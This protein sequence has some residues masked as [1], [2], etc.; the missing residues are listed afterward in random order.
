MFKW[1]KKLIVD[2]T[3]LMFTR[4]CWWILPICFM[5]GFSAPSFF[6]NNYWIMLLFG[7]LSYPLALLVA[8]SELRVKNNKKFM[9]NVVEHVV[10]S[11]QKE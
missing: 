5:F 7:V 4:D 9:H 11:K 6:T 1:R 10:E 8:M 2:C 3:K